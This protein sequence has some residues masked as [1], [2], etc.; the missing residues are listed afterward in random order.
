LNIQ[1]LLRASSIWW[2]SLS[3]SLEPRF[4]LPPGRQLRPPPPV[5][6]PVSTIMMLRSIAEIA[7]SHGEDPSDPESA[8]SCIQVFALG[9]RVGSADASESGYF[10]VLGMLAK[11]VTEAARFI[12]ERGIVEEG[13]QCWS[14]SLH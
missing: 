7:R 14:V 1:V 8:L 11:S 13:A 10:A 2:V 9:G 6:L 3:S 12:A 5:E 4:Q